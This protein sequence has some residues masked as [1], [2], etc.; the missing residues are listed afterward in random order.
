[1]RAIETGRYLLRATNTGVT[2]IVEPNGTVRERAQSFEY[3]L[4]LGTF[5]PMIGNTP[6]IKFGNYLIV[7]VLILNLFL[8]YFWDRNRIK[9]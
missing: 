1:M 4:L 6:Y 3:S 5:E 2:A 8:G 7:V 9:I